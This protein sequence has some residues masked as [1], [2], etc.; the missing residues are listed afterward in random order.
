[1][2]QEI[3]EFFSSTPFQMAVN[4]RSPPFFFVGY[5]LVALA[6]VTRTLC[7][8]LLRRKQKEQ[9]KPE[10]PLAHKWKSLFEMKN[11]HEQFERVQDD[12]DNDE[13]ESMQVQR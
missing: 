8:T 4:I 13:E 3:V 2:H 11:R 6:P 1:M 10:L 5:V 12:D 9:K 7:H